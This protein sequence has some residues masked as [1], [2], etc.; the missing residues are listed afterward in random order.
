MWLNNMFSLL[1]NKT[2]LR[3][4]VAMK[5][6]TNKLLQILTL[7][8]KKVVLSMMAGESGRQVIQGNCTCGISS[9]FKLQFG[10]RDE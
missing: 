4:L 2:S 9:C 5:G 3:S 6:M 8:C 10:L 1:N 7:K